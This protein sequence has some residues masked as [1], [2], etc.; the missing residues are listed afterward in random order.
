MSNKRLTAVW[1]KSTQSG[2]KLLVLLSLADR[3]DDDGF[4]WPSLKD[5]A[6]RSR[7]QRSYATTLIRE[8][9]KDGELYIHQRLG[10]TNQYI[11]TVGLTPQEIKTALMRRFKMSAND[12]QV[13][14]SEILT[15]QGVQF[16]DTT[17][18]VNLTGGVQSTGHEPSYNPNE[19]KEAVTGNS[20]S[21]G[22]CDACGKERPRLIEATH[23]GIAY[24]ACDECDIRGTLPAHMRLSK[25]GHAA[26]IDAAIVGGA[27]FELN[28]ENDCQQFLKFSPNWNNKTEREL[29]AF[30]KERVR[31]GQTVRQFSLWYSQS[32]WKGKQGQP[33]SSKDIRE[34][35]YA[36]FPDTL[37][38]PVTTNDGGL[39]V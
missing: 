3:A 11:V 18:P 12:A 36:A 28:I 10:F 8:I 7:T 39:Y 24:M 2:T 27:N 38:T 4:C 9:E 14:V 29:M 20:H 17:P 13:R 19:P 37:T 22:V 5:T 26:R 30:L 32:H 31:A 33:P 21:G 34:T 6:Q 15:R 35:W 1:D 23:K 25:N 16:T